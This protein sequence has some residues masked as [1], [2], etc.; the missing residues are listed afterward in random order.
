MPDSSTQRLLGRTSLVL[1]IFL[2]ACTPEQ[3]AQSTVPSVFVSQVRHD[4]GVEQRV[5]FGQVRPRVEA[6]L[7]FRIGGK[8]SERLVEVG[9]VVLAGQPLARIDPSDY[10]LAAGIAEEQQRAAEVDAVQAASD[11]SRLRRLLA[12]GSTGAADYERQQ[13]RSD[14]AAA[15]LTQAQKQTELARNRESYAVLIAPFDGVVTAVRF[16]VG[17]VVDERFPLITL[18]RS[19]DL[20]VVVD[21]P[22]T[23]VA[24]LKGWQARVAIGA[25][26]SSEV[27]L[28][29]LRLREIAASANVQTRTT[30]ARYA[31]ENA[32]DAMNWRIGISAEVQLLR[33]GR[34]PG[35]DLPLGALLVTQ[36]PADPARTQGA[37]EPLQVSSPAV[38]LVDSQTGALTRQSVQLLSQTADRVRVAGLAEGAMVITVGAHKLDAGMKVRPIL[39]PEASSNSVPGTAQVGTATPAAGAR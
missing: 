14:A 25:T 29:A 35:A 22:E 11:A 10:R 8:V 12:D 37:P 9:Q 3:P 32:A 13:A 39:R 20:E 31:P 17:Q 26:S 5:L 36:A 15:R 23:L 28:H 38:W 34:P 21:I 19:R 18:A 1:C 7:S 16:E 2:A 27:R 24:G 33:T 6:E 30:R 4:R